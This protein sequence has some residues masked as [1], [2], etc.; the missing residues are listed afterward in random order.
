[1]FKFLRKGATSLLAKVFLGVIAIVFVFWGIGVFTYGRKELIGKVNGNPISIK[2]FQEYY[3][4]QIFRLKQTFGELSPEDLKK[5]KI[6]QQVLE[7]LIKIKIIENEAKNLGINISPVEIN[8]AIS[9]IPSFQE[10]GV[11][12]P[13]KYKYILE[14]LGISSNFFEF[15]IK[16]DLIQQRLKL[17]LTAPII[18]SDEEVRDYI[19]YN[20]QT[21]TLLEGILPINY[22]ESKVSFTEKDLE[23]YYLAHR[24]IYKENEKVKLYYLFIPY[25]GKVDVSSKEIKEFYEENL[26]RFKQPFRVKLR[27]IYIAG[28]DSKA[29]QKA[30]KIKSKL[31]KLKDFDKYGAQPSQWFEETALPEDLKNTIKQS[32]PSQIIGPIKISTGY[33]IL[34]IEKIQPERLLKLEEV[35]SE[36]K[37]FLKDKKIREL[38]KRKVDKIYSEIVK[39]NGLKFW[40]K[41]NNI[42]LSETGWLTQRQAIELLK[43]FR[44]VRK[45]FQSPKGEYF[46]PIETSKGIMIIEIKDKKP[47]RILSFKEVKEKV[48]KDYLNAKGKEFCEE[49]AQSFFDKIKDKTL[50]SAKDF[51]KKG[52]RLKKIKCK[53]YELNKYFDPEIAQELGKIGKPKLLNKYF[54]DK[55][56]LKIFYV[57][58]IRPFNGTITDQEI[59]QVSSILLQNKREVWFNRWYQTLRKKAKI[60]LY[61]N[62]E[63][64]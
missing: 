15:I 53:R 36:I 52:F 12:S 5:L 61:Q 41:K 40:A 23:N 26:S 49:K 25:K 29:F 62:L 14:Q 9:Q 48:K 37:G 63:R 47:P 33:L 50:L 19:K 31:K 55:E 58:E 27:T 43:D 57:E 32:K 38:T 1:M 30:Q 13:R 10:N 8:Y 6:K 22:C 17:L 24:D 39:E 16:S 18:V 3:N 34:G 64:F 56:G 11:F 42:K 20:K 28:K 59:L 60:K 21:L 4:F 35:K 45:I 51:S 54:W 7:N 2:D 44:L 46:A